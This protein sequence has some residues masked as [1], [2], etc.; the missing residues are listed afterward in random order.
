[1]SNEKITC[2]KRVALVILNW[3]GAD[4]MRRFLPGVVRNTPEADIIV[5]DNGSTDGSPDMLA[6][7]FP[8]VRCLPFSRN[9]GFAE[10]Y[11]KA[12]ELID[13]EFYLLL[14]SD[15]E[16]SPGWL[17]PLLSHMDARPGDAAC[18]PKLLSQ[19]DKAFFEYAGAAGGYIDRYGYP[20]C[21][22]RVFSTVERDRGQYDASAACLWATGAA[23]LVRAADWHAA[24]GLDAR[25]FAHM[26]EIDF[27]WRLRCRGRGVACVP[28]SVAYHVGGATLGAE[29]PR[30]TFLNF[31]NNLLMLYKNLPAPELKSVMRRRALLDW[32]AATQML[33]T[34]RFRHARAVL[35]ARRA[36]HRLKP[37]FRPQREENLAKTVDA[38]PTGRLPRCLVA[39]YYLRRK[40]TFTALAP[41][42]EAGN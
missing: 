17:P 37:Q 26:E 19:R 11:D 30:K 25:F 35:Q 31:R 4:M 1:M 3:N 7:E 13:A 24:G 40:H 6:R 14:N 34:G 9:Y 23:L 36:Y 15:V 10:G 5:A 2:R 22:G 39:L 21:R 16:V 20:F 27:C 29:N 33:L 42:F 38:R 41:F 18:Q 28:Q 32:V 12:F 8:T